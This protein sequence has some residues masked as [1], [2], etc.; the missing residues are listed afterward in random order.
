MNPRRPDPPAAY[1][2]AG[3]QTF[4]SPE[5]ILA[6]PAYGDGADASIDT[7]TGGVFATWRQVGSP[8][9]WSVRTPLG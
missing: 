3:T 5:E 7:A 9:A 6:G 1:H 8:L 2:P 4:G